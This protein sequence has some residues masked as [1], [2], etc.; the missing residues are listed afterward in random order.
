MKEHTLTMKYKT[1]LDKFLPSSLDLDDKINDSTTPITGITIAMEVVIRTLD[2]HQPKSDSVVDEMNFYKDKKCTDSIIDIDSFWRYQ[3]T[4]AQ[5]LMISIPSNTFDVFVGM[6]NQT[7]TTCFDWLKK[8]LPN[9]DNIFDYG[10]IEITING[11][12]HFSRVFVLNAWKALDKKKDTDT[13]HKTSVNEE[14]TG[15]IPLILLCNSSGLFG[16]HK[17]G[18]VKEFVIKV[19]KYLRKNLMQDN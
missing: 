8:R 18:Q 2:T 7:K 5:R 14:H 1:I 10:C 12:D 6:K 9:L 13:C 15:H 19:L 16:V 17:I 3:N 4:S 11:D